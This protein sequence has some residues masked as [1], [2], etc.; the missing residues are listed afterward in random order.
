MNIYTKLKR[1]EFETL[2]NE[3]EKYPATIKSFTERLKEND[4]IYALKLGDIWDLAKITGCQEGGSIDV[5][6][7][8]KRFI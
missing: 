4:N 5:F 3:A 2:N 6:K 1:E 8:T 7:L